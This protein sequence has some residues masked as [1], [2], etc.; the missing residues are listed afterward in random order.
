MLHIS[1]NLVGRTLLYQ[2]SRDSNVKVDI[3]EEK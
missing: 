1:H 2:I 3:S